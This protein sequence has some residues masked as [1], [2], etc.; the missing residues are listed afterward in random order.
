MLSSSVVVGPASQ[1]RHR[2]FGAAL[3]VALMHSL[4]WVSSTAFIPRLSPPLAPFASSV[5]STPPASS[6]SYRGL[7]RA[8]RPVGR[9]EALRLMAG[10]VSKLEVEPDTEHR[11]YIINCA[12][13]MEM[14]VKKLLHLKIERH[15]L[16][17]DVPQVVVPTQT[18]SSTRG[19][20]IYTKERTLYPSYV[21]VEMCMTQH[22]YDILLTTDH[23]INFV[24]RDH[25]VRNNGGS[26]LTGARGLVQPYPLRPQEIKQFQLNNVEGS[27]LDDPT[28]GFTIGEMIEVTEGPNQGERGPVRL[29][30]DG[31]LVVRLYAYGMSMDLE[32][33]PK[34]VKKL[35]E[36]DFVAAPEPEKKKELTPGQVAAAERR[37]KRKAERYAERQARMEE[38]MRN[39]PKDH[40][41]S[42]L[43]SFSQLGGWEDE[44]THSGAADNGNNG[45]VSVGGLQWET[46][47]EGSEETRVLNLDL[48]G[49]GVVSE[50]TSDAF[51][52][53][54]SELLEADETDP[55][56]QPAREPIH[57][58]A[59]VAEGETG[60][61]FNDISDLQETMEATMDLEMD[62]M[63]DLMADLD[64]TSGDSEVAARLE[65]SG[66]A[67]AASGAEGS[68]QQSDGSNFEGVAAL[69]E[70]MQ[71]LTVPELKELLRER[72]LKVGGKKSDLIQ[73]LLEG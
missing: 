45:G 72:G 12:T 67:E 1:C 18:L 68:D 43:D 23:V 34:I 38:R 60:S 59:D 44:G 46:Q 7:D 24:G 16:Q 40:K 31:F 8:P 56:Q 66:S 49:A 41:T 22:S 42:A 53:S 4:L 32:F 25:G 69:E 47:L 36:V 37:A 57:G 13:G 51:L 62:F 33:D 61:S 65:A 48:T 3:V 63:D 70:E 64:L 5:S 73:R 30:R 52:D 27:K 39:T 54:L 20:K 6:S 17:A 14:T 11:W 21:F 19:K 26:A 2:S 15:D 50:E 29:V 9:E 55:I 35:D 58:K 28:L 10:P 71:S